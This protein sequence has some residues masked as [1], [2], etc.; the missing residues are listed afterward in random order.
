M[1]FPSKIEHASIIAS[2]DK[3]ENFLHELQREGIC[4]IAKLENW[5]ENIIDEYSDALTLKSEIE[6]IKDELHQYKP[7]QKLNPIE[8]L[9]PKERMIEIVEDRSIEEIIQDVRKEV[10]RLKEEIKTDLPELKKKLED[11]MEKLR[12]LEIFPKD[13]DLSVYTNSDKIRVIT[14]LILTKNESNIRDLPGVKI[15]KEVDKRT[16]F[17]AIFFLKKDSELVLSKVHE[18][19][20]SPVKPPEDRGKP[21]DVR[22]NILKR[23]EVLKEEINKEKERLA[24][25]WET[26]NKKLDMVLDEINIVTSRL[27]ALGSMETGY[28]LAR[29]NVWIP[30]KNWKRFLKLVKKEL[31]KYYIIAEEKETAPTL[32]ENPQPIKAFERI[33]ALYGFPK[34]GRIDPT[35]ILA[36]SFALFFGF[37]LTDAAYGLAMIAIGLLAMIGI[38]RTKPEMKDFSFVIILSGI[39]TLILG[40]LFGS[41]LGSLLTDMFHI[42]YWIDPMK[43]ATIVL[44]IAL[45]LG[46]THISIGLTLGLIEKIKK[47]EYLDALRPSVTMLTFILGLLVIVCGGITGIDLTGIGLT[48][49]GISIALN[50]V[51]AYLQNGAIL[52]GLSIF[53]YT[54]FLGDWFSY[55]RLMSLALG[56]GGIALA[57]NFMA[58]LANNMIPVIGW[59]IALLIIVLGHTFNMGINALGAFVHSLRLHFLEFFSKFYVGGGKPYSPFHAK[60]RIME[61]R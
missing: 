14:G 11:E 51:G 43:Q 36:F 57:V 46:L 26:K 6:R 60:K 47:K 18:I 45:I 37:M 54:G 15:I 9:F 42:P 53:D 29:L 20:F 19:G 22:A 41:W 27:E 49:I 34:Y 24:K 28:A 5:E 17:L 13:V 32:L 31:G 56:T 3:L 39:F 12:D 2:K 25:L 8:I 38:G 48:L 44:G 16:S 10:S 59:I 30:E 21:S 7:S 50:F 58:G 40:A 1:F 4:Q 61:V 35:P 23:I 33:T 52:A 55:A